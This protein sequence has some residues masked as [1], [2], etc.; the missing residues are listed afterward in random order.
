MVVPADLEDLEDV[1]APS[2]KAAIAAV[3]E[4]TPPRK[5]FHPARSFPSPNATHSAANLSPHTSHSPYGSPPLSPPLSE[6]SQPDETGEIFF[7]CHPDLHLNN[8]LFDPTSRTIT[9]ILDWENAAFEPRWSWRD[10]GYPYPKFLFGPEDPR[11]PDYTST[12]EEETDWD[13]LDRQLW[14][15]KPLRAVFLNEIAEVMKASD[16]WREAG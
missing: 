8:I 6:T 2:I 12:T 3:Y 9:E 7:L 5:V 1:L 4:A 16:I 14:E 10:L 13:R 11:E 15:A